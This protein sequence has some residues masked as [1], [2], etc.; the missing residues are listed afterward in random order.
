[1]LMLANRV[2]S[3]SVRGKLRRCG[4]RAAA[5]SARKGPHPGNVAQ[6]GEGRREGDS[7]ARSLTAWAHRRRCVARLRRTNV[8]RWPASEADQSFRQAR[9]WTAQGRPGEAEANE[10]SQGKQGTAERAVPPSPCAPS[11]RPRSRGH[12]RLRHEGHRPST[13]QSQFRPP[14]TKSRSS[15]CCP[16]GCDFTAYLQAEFVNGMS[17]MTLTDTGIAVR[18]IVPMIQKASGLEMAKCSI[19]DPMSLMVCIEFL[20]GGRC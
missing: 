8:R 1:M 5:C 12:L 9:R 15:W 2:R 13:A 19:F 7:R 6:R 4:P 16:G 14:D 3:G 20:R 17:K 10:G 11:S 18:M